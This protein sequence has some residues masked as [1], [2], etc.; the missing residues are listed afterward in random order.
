M[1]VELAYHQIER[2]FAVRHLSGG[3]APFEIFGHHVHNMLQE[4]KH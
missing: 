3:K 4:N 2:L 1:V